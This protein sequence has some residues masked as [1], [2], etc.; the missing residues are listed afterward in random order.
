MSAYPLLFSEWKIRNTTIKNRVVFPPTCPSWISDPWN[1]VFTDM[2]TAY[3]EE[4]ARGGVGLIIIGATHVHPDSII[5]PLLLSQLFDDRNIEPLAKIV[6]VCHQYDCKLGIQLTHTGLRGS[7]G[8]KQE[9][10]YDLNATWYTAAPS[11]VPLGEF[12]G[13]GTPKELSE[14]EIYEILDAFEAA[15]ARAGRAGVDGVELHA[16]HGYLL[17][18]FLSPL[19]NKRTDRW[20]GTYENRLRF[21]VEVLRRMRKGIGD[22]AFLGYRINSTS[23]W[24]NDLEPDDLKQIVPDIERQADVDYVSVSAGVHHAFIHTP[25]E[26]EPGW[27]KGYAKAIRE[28]SS[29]PVLVVGKITTPDV[30]EAILADGHAD[31]VCLA[32]QMFADPEWAVKAQEGR[33][34]DIRKCVAANYCWRTVS[35]AGR[36]QCVYNPTIGRER[37]W[38]SGTLHTVE[39]PKRV[40][41]IG[42]GPAGLEYARVAAARGHDVVVMER[43]AELGGHVRV[44]SLLPT[45]GEYN[46]IATWLARQAQQN[47]AE[48]RVSSAVTPEN[49]D[50]VLARERPDHVIVATGAR[51]CKDGFQG[52]TGAPLPGW[53]T[54][55]CAGWDEV[56]TEKVKPS[57]DVM[58]LD[59]VCDVVAPLC[60]FGL[61]ENGASSVKLVTR[62]PMVGMDTILDVYLEWLMP[63]LYKS[64]VQM[65]TDHFVRK[66]DGT[67][68]TLY[69]VYIESLEAQINADWIV[70]VTARNSENALYGLVKDHGISV[71]TIG[72]ATAPRHTYEA[73]YEGHRQARKV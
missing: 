65:I 55:N 24:P 62:W 39:N 69:N 2:A 20:G 33:E 45:R 61:A 27:E 51:I 50:Q 30:A 13:S 53:E 68:V 48:I 18:E 37:Q 29:K 58:V 36:V 34:D 1:A 5:A 32:R 52:W 59:D 23:F 6:E 63:K 17:W 14:E 72:D 40:L 44:Q 38:G 25:M 11:Q 47:G 71:E 49:L 66:I 4:R 42:G 3:Y 67:S 19:Y 60:A 8:F 57:G 15:A 64:G 16:N 28:V 22:E 26:F 10:A 35:L 21:P 7:P 56:V 31:A 43:E 12:P 41:I 54:A 46:N 9:P 70:M 73:V